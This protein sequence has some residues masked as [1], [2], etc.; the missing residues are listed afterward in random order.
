MGF[1]EKALAQ[2][3]RGERINFKFE[4]NIF[5]VGIRKDEKHETNHVKQETNNFLLLCFAKTQSWSL[6]ERTTS[7]K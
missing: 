3:Y 4:N 7:L 1:F 5:Q 2:Y 6:S